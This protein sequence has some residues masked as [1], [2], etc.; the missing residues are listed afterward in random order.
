M[1]EWIDAFYSPKK[2]LPQQYPWLDILKLNAVKIDAAYKAREDAELKFLNLI[3][4]YIK[5]N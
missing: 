5:E 4:N 1:S 3:R 2:V